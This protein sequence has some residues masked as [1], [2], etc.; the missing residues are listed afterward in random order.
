MSSS[1]T[2][3]DDSTGLEQYKVD[4]IEKAME[5]GVLLFGEFTLKSG[6]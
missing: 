2:K 5:K 4:F 3:R 6:R 1:I